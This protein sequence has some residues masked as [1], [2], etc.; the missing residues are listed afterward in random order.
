MLKRNLQEMFLREKLIS[1][2]KKGLHLRKNNKEIPEKLIPD[3]CLYQLCHIQRKIVSEYYNNNVDTKSD[4][5][6]DSVGIIKLFD[7]YFKEKFVESKNLYA[8]SMLKKDRSILTVL[9]SISS[10]LFC[11]KDK[12]KNY[13]FSSSIT[14]VLYNLKPIRG[15]YYFKQCKTG[16]D[17]LYFRYPDNIVPMVRDIHVINISETYETVNYISNKFILLFKLNISEKNK[18]PDEPYQILEVIDVYDSDGSKDSY[19]QEIMGSSYFRKDMD[20]STLEK[21]ADVSNKII[22]MCY[23]SSIYLT[24]P[25]EDIISAVNEF[26]K[27]K[28]KREYEKKHYTSESFFNVDLNYKLVRAYEQDKEW[29]TNGHFRL[30]PVGKN[31]EKRKLT[32]VKPHTKH[33]RLQF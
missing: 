31:R 4:L 23:A 11:K 22:N 18:R 1:S 8:A 7:K 6:L 30:Q 15:D 17:V 3:L 2:Y 21:L 27:K 29:F 16:Y 28:T 24:N 5:D 33:R 14:E 32:F 10:Y 20:E 13:V 26:S 9:T 25:T 12:I 19:T